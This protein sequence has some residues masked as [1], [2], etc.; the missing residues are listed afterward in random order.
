MFRTMRESVLVTS[1]VALVVVPTV[2][3]GGAAETAAAAAPAM[4]DAEARALMVKAVD[5][6]M[7]FTSYHA[8]A[9]VTGRNW[10]WREGSNLR[11][12]D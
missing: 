12:P 2:G 4:T 3:C 7:K 6:S 1:L 11:P 10:L 9:T 8:S 5:V